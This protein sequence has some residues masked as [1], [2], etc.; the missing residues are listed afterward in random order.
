MTIAPT[1]PA[2]SEIGRRA[3]SENF[4]VASLLLG[5]RTRATLLAIYGFARLVDELGDAIDGD[6]LAALDEAEAELDRAYA[7][8]PRTETFRRLS[9]AIASAG[10][11]RE[12]FARL[13]EANRQD[14]RQHDYETFDDLLAYCALSASPV[15]ELV[16]A[17]FGVAT[18]D[19]V[20]L[21]ND[22]CNAL[23]VIEHVQD[24]REDA[25]AGRVYLPREDCERFGV[26]GRQLTDGTASPEL[27]ALLAF[28][29]GRAA[30]LLRSG[31]PLVGSLRGRARIAVAGYVGGGIA[32]LAAIEAAGYD[33][34]HA[35]P[36]ATR[37]ARAA[38]ALRVVRGRR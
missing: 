33:V 6:R 30:A 38:A 25:Q 17:A 11:P 12:P 9:A 18:P 16:L 23:Q 10:L 37:S 1:F 8:N 15:G 36:K 7:G 26:A 2:A 14:Q 35:T 21:S 4:E 24:V 3:R 34:L 31:W 27:R 28:E 20:A 32:T 22:V 19:R 13:I 29:C 5:A